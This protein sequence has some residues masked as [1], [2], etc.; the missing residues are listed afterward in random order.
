[1]TKSVQAAN[2]QGTHWCL[3]FFYEHQ[4]ENEDL[5]REEERKVLIDKLTKI[6]LVYL[7]S[8]TESCPSSKR[9]HEQAACITVERYRFDQFCRFVPGVHVEHMRKASWRSKR[10]CQ[11]DGNFIEIGSLPSEYSNEVE[12]ASQIAKEII[13]LSTEGKED[14]IIQRYPAQYMRQY[15]TIRK[16]VSDNEA[17][18]P[19]GRKVCIWLYSKEYFRTG[20]STF[21]AT[22][23][24]LRK[25]KTYWHP[26]FGHS[27]FWERF[28]AKCET[29]VF[30]DIDTTTPWLGSTLKR[31][32]SDTP[33]IVNQKF[34]SALP[35]LKNILVCSNYLPGKLWP[36]EIGD[37]VSAR[38]VFL[39][40]VRHN[41]RDLLVTPLEKPNILFPLSLIKLLNE[42]YKFNLIGNSENSIN[43][44]DILGMD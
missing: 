27:D 29:V 42:K 30:D 18:I 9:I 4:A 11:K 41:G 6:G 8:G 28:H 40:A 14:E 25:G 22:H 38:F 32:T 36:N 15:N 1:M 43:E 3:T 33:I 23:F 10:Y 20:K 12:S 31:I 37:A 2:P 13:K 44:L 17:W 24:P 26:Q 5:Q 16:I 39:Q 7:I 21:L 35:M 34:G 19:S